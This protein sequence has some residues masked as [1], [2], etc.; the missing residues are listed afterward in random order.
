MPPV[1]PT[2]TRAIRLLSTAS[3]LAVRDGDLALGELLEGHRQVVLGAGLDE[4]RR[5]VVEGALAELVVVV[6][7]LP[8]PLGRD[9]HQ[10]VARVDVVQEL[11]D[12]GMD[13][14]PDM[15]AAA[16]SSRLT[17]PASSSVARSRSSFSIA[18]SN[19]S[20]TSS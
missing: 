20:A 14:R 5:E 2:R 13:H 11:I 19:R 17:M 15:V 18:W 10:R 7:D 4:R 9:D 16:S 6:V 1:T 12:A 3:G 8:G